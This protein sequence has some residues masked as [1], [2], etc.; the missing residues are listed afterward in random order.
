[1]KPT[2]ADREK[3][4]LPESVEMDIDRPMLSDVKRLKV[5]VGMSWTDLRNSLLSQDLFAAGVAMW[6]AVRRS[7]VDVPWSDFDT[8]ITST[9]AEIPDDDP[10]SSAPDGAKTRSMSSRRRSAASTA[11]T[12]GTSKGSPRRSSPR[13][14]K[15]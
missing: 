15:S 1:M 10:N 14:S 6:I 9:I 11:S 13:T 2:D 8:D 5:D 7:G 3:Y 12:R 4:G